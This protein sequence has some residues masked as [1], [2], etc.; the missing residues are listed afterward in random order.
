MMW[1]LW[2]SSLLL[3]SLA[4]AG[5]LYKFQN[6]PTPFLRSLSAPQLLLLRHAQGARGTFF[7]YAFAGSLIFFS[8]L[9]YVLHGRCR[10]AAPT[11][12]HD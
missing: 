8:L 6:F 11:S 2:I 1:V 10:G 4:A 12:E 7:G 5:L 9:V 3:W